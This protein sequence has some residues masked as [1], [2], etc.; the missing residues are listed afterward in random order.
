MGITILIIDDDMGDIKNF[1]DHVTEWHSKYKVE[2]ETEFNKA[3]EKIKEIKENG[4]KL[5]AVF[6]D[7]CE[8]KANYRPVGL[9]TIAAI[10]EDF[11]EVL[12]VAYTQYEKYHAEALQRGADWVWKKQDLKE[13]ALS[14]LEDRIRK[15]NVDHKKV[16]K[17]LVGIDMITQ[18]LQNF[19]NSILKITRNRRK[20]HA[21]FKLKD[22]YD[23]QDLVYTMLKPIFIDLVEEDPSP[24]VAG[25]GSRIDI[26]IPTRKVVI[27]TKMLKETDD[28]ENLYINDL[29]KDIESYHKHPDLEYLICLV[30]DPYK[31]CKD[32]NNF[33]ELAGE[34]MVKGKQFNVIMIV[35]H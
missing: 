35:Q 13:L 25:R 19:S 22:E 23:V 18:I 1:K 14:G 30:Y 10:R 28:N 24:K 26:V 33:Y 34:R 31:K 16:D 20:D 29:K 5:A 32:D 17:I 21:V 27:E 15:H 6:I 9:D 11:D 3:K 12:I 4:D 2:F 7:I 8:K